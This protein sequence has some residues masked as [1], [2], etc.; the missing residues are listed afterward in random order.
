MAF[1]DLSGK[2]YSTT[3]KTSLPAVYVFLS[4]ECPVSNR[5]APR[6]VAAEKAYRAKGVHF[7]AVYPMQGED[8]AAI[9]RHAKERGISFPVIRDDGALTKAFQATMTPEVVVVDRAAQIRY[10]GL[11][12]DNTDSSRVR[13]RYL[14]TALDAILA[15]KP[16]AVAKTKAIGCEITTQPVS[17]TAVP[18]D[19]TTVTYARDIAPILNTRCVSCHR[20]GQVGPFAL[21]T[22][23]RAARWAKAIKT[24]TTARR[25]PP[26]KADS[27]GEFQDEMRLSDDERTKLAAWADSGALSGD[28]KAASAPPK[29]PT[30]WKIGTPDVIFSPSEPF[31]VPAEGRDQY[32]CFV[33]P[34]GFTEDVWISGVEYEPGNRA[35]VHHMSAFVDTSGQ[36]RKMADADLA[37]PGYLN[38]TPGN[39][40][41]FTPVAA[42]LG[43][44]TPGHSP[45]ILPDGMGIKVPKGGDIVI[46]VHY[47]PNGKP[48]TDR[49]RVGLRFAK[50]PIKKLLRIG[51]VSDFAF[52]IPPGAKEHKVEFSA[53]VPEDITLFSISPHM[54]NLGRSMVA[55]VTF[56]DGTKHSLVAVPDWDFRWQ[57]SYRFKEPLKLPRRARIDVVAIFDNSPENP[58]NPHHPPKEIHW[59]EGTDDE[60]CTLFVAYTRDDEDLTAEPVLVPAGP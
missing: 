45:R 9:T 34:T 30:G 57:P 6:L 21:D 33:I 54:H 2:T 52:K 4:V 5:Y 39:G 55:T 60:M 7:Y 35:V 51:D 3:A 29:F 12:D 20:E 31:P 46:E 48:E 13:S 58:N 1:R 47:H 23:E 15:G 22:Y 8:T 11:I 59:G 36:A 19:P 49:P 14:T 28:L 43:G 40:P 26:W 50:G 38:P 18:K 53:F 27:H 32:R 56:P 17:V 37:T 16:V 25:M 24:E 42:Q 41:G 10:R 44:W